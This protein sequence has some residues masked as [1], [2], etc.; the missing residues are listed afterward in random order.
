MLLGNNNYGNNGRW[1]IIALI[2]G[3]PIQAVPVKQRREHP[4]AE[5]LMGPDDGS[6]QIISVNL[7]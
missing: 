2:V 5:L 4:C 7:Q 6:T 1:E 3:E